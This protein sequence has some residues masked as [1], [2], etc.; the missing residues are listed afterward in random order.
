[1]VGSMEDTVTRKDAIEEDT[2]AVAG[3]G[4]GAEIGRRG[5]ETATITD[6][7]ANGENT[8]GQ[9]ITVGI[10]ETTDHHDA[11]MMTAQGSIIRIKEARV[12]IER[13][14]GC[15]GVT[16]EIG[17]AVPRLAGLAEKSAKN[18][19]QGTGDEAQVRKAG[20]AEVLNLRM[21]CACVYHL[22]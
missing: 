6:L 21:T 3:V 10:V 5:G 19:A 13:T 18:H 9:G 1:M 15:K 12:G 4:T 11:H 16:E 22:Q 8:N 7:E 2:E 17:V 20:G 14:T